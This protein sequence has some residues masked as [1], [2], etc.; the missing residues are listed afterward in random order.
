MLHA[1]PSC[2]V[3]PNFGTWLQLYRCNNRGTQY[4]Y[5]CNDDDCPHCGGHDRHDSEIAANR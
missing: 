2:G 3:K 5:K 4:C 1:C